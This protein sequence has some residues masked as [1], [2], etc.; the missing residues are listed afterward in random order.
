M[1]VNANFL[2]KRV[3]GL[4]RYAL[5]LSLAIQNYQNELTFLSPRR[6]F[7]NS[8][9]DLSKLKI[10]K[11]GYSKNYGWEQIE[12][13]VFLRRNK[14]PLLINLTNTAPVIYRNQ[15]TVIHDLAFLHNPDWYSKKAAMF[16]KW[17]VKRSVLASKHIITVSNFSKSEIQK[18]YDIAEDKISVVHE[19]IPSKFLDLRGNDF[20]NRWGDYLLTVSSLEPRKNLINLIKAFSKLNLKGLKLLIVG[21]ANRIVFQEPSFN[22]LDLSKNIEFLGYVDDETLIGLYKNAKLFAYISHYEGFG[23]PPLEALVSGCPVLVSNTDCLREVLVDKVEYCNPYDVN[24]IADKIKELIN[25]LKRL[26]AEETRELLTK[27]NREKCAESFLNVI[28][29]FS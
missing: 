28:S 2:T 4:E 9:Y 20:P 11:I 7:P 21:V 8:H 5:E 18:Y 13:P 27:Y 24:D 23:L 19:A 22:E 25:T 16:F 1:Y 6:E 15:I 26:T 12:L 29:R 3:T 10:S 17:L 14:S